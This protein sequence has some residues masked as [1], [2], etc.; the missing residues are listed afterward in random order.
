MAGAKIGGR[1]R[2]RLMGLAGSL[3]A[4]A[5]LCLLR[6]WSHVA[7][8]PGAM[9]TG[10]LLYGLLLLLA[11]FN[12][13]KKLPFL[14]LCKASTWL[15]WHL[16][17]G[18]VSVVLFFLHAGF[19]PPSGVVETILAVIFLL[20]AG[21]GVIGIVISRALPVQMTRS[22][23]PLVYER[24]PRYRREI[25]VAVRELAVKAE[26]TCGSSSIPDFVLEVVEPYLGA[27]ASFW[28]PLLG[29]EHTRPRRL[30]QELE[31]RLRYFSEEEE[32]VAAELRE[33]IETKEN[34]DFQ[35][36]AQRWLKGWLFVH[37]PL[38]FLLLLLGVVHGVL[39]MIYRGTIG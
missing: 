8:L 21:S 10:F 4:V 25:E 15:Q 20:V 39:A 29:R 38:T 5:G 14:P 12:A 3:V 28:M 31:A 34:L 7:L 27:R 17:A 23:E 32:A 9:Y 37:I 19:A 33:W 6:E 13:R 24:I 16:Y 18:L 30:Y 2:R 22:G 36:A 11:L 35:E 1:K 26:K